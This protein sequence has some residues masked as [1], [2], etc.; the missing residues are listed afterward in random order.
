MN[1]TSEL[2]QI[3]IGIFGATGFTGKEVLRQ[4]LERGWQVTILVRDANKVRVQHALLNVVVGDALN[5]SDVKKVIQ[6]QNVIVQCLGV[7]GFGD[8]KPNSFVSDAT[9]IIVSAMQDLKVE[10]LICMSNVGVGGSHIPWIMRKVVLP[11]FLK[12]L[13]LI[14]QDKEVMESVVTQSG[15]SWTIARFP[16]IVERKSKNKIHVTLDGKGNGLDISLIE[17]AKFLLDQATDTAYLHKSACIS[18]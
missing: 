16:N 6:G 5:V 13:G 7:G 15:L 18:N 2:R 3:R 17:S 10:R 1:S 11:Y 14:M 8:G 12:G 4:A 9:K